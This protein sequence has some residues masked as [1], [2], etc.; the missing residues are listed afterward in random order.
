MNIC[1]YIWVSDKP[2]IIYILHVPLLGYLKFLPL[3]TQSPVLWPPDAKN[4]LTVKDPDVGKDWRQEEKGITED[5]IVGWHHRLNG[6]EFEQ[7]LGVG[8]GQ[9]GLVC[10]SPWG[11][12]ESDRTEGLSN[13]TE[14]T[15]THTH[16]VF[17]LSLPSWLV[18]PYSLESLPLFHYQ[19]ALDLLWTI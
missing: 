15:H 3:H 18:A 4:W 9:G 7:T 6:H 16:R 2:R 8:D 13:W 14:H 19:T 11:R 1:T 17:S 12:K 5:E 10:C